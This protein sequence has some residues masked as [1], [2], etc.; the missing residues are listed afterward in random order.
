MC[1][2][3]ALIRIALSSRSINVDGT[4]NV[5]EACSST[6]SV[7]ALVFTSTVNI[8][9]TGEELLDASEEDHEEEEEDLTYLDEYSRTKHE[10]ERIVL[11]ANGENLKTCSLR[12]A[13]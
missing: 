9:F 8:R 2:T 5:V 13:E 11:S 1:K 7:R 4:R 3:S 10:A 12:Y 6:D